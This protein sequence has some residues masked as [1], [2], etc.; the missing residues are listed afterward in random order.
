[1]RTPLV[2]ELHPTIVP[3]SVSKMNGTGSEVAN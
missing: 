3:P 2:P 1:M